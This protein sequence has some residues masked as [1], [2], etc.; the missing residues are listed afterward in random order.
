MNETHDP[1]LKSWVESANDPD[2]DFPIQNLP[3][4]V[5]TFPGDDYP[6]TGVAIGDQILDIAAG[7]ESGGVHLTPAAPIAC[8]PFLNGLA[9]ADLVHIEKLRSQVSSLLSYGSERR[10]DLLVP[11]S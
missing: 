8:Q 2:T 9:D 3:F 5:F 6:R 11:M 4:G 7:V 1:S 10:H